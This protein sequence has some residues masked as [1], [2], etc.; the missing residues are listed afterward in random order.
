MPSIPIFV[1]SSSFFPSPFIYLFYFS[2]T[3]YQQNIKHP[4]IKDWS[5]YSTSR[6]K[7]L[8]S[9]FFHYWFLDLFHS[10]HQIFFHLGSLF[11]SLPVFYFSSSQS[12]TKNIIP[13]TSDY[14]WRLELEII[15]YL[16][17]ELS[18]SLQAQMVRLEKWE[19]PC[20]VVGSVS[21]RKTLCIFLLCCS[22]LFRKKMFS[23]ELPLCLWNALLKQFKLKFF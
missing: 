19:S 14:Y 5:F 16:V 9:I 2:T 13:I 10:P 11:L 1:R 7:G 8:I 18:F 15:F 6:L 12:H 23:K 4:R 20:L 17:I 3:L 22:L 21:L